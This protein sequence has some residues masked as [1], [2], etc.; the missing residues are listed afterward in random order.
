MNQSKISIV[1]EDYE[2]SEI[3]MDKL[4]DDIGLV[5]IAGKLQP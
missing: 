5:P 2:K 4:L 1:E 3:K